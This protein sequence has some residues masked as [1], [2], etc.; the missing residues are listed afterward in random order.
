M[1]LGQFI[2]C[3]PENMGILANFY[4]CAQAHPGEGCAVPENELLR[5]KAI[6][7]NCPEYAYQKAINS[8]CL[9]EYMTM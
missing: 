8:S 3:N 4:R 9:S 6:D 5:H 7:G 2:K 1:L